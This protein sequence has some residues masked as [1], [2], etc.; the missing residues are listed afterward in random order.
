MTNFTY[1]NPNEHK[2]ITMTTTQ[3]TVLGEFIIGDDGFYVFF[4][5]PKG[6]Y[7]NEYFLQVLLNK[8]TELNK[9]WNE[10]INQYFAEN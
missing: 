10:Q 1:S 5:E 2:T 9:E 3:G 8:L 6:G 4:S 7:Y